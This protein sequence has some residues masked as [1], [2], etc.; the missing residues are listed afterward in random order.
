MLCS[1]QAHLL[2]FFKKDVTNICWASYQNQI[3]SSDTSKPLVQAPLS[4]THEDGVGDHE[5]TVKM[6]KDTILQAVGVQKLNHAENP[7]IIREPLMH[8]HH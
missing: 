7:A 5:A 3:C 6:T 4:A 8:I 2:F 1:L